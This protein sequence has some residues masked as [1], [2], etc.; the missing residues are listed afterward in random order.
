MFFMIGITNGRKDPDFHQTVICDRCGRYGSYK[1]YI[2]YMQ[3][4][5][6]FIPCFKWNRQY[7]VETSCCG[8]VYSLDPEVGKRIARGEDVTI[9]PDDLTPLSYGSGRRIRTCPSCGYSTEEAFEY[10]PMC[11]SKF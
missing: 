5:L 8:T 1:V 9:T 4:L 6:F 11:G 7:F 2:T 10:C 3:L